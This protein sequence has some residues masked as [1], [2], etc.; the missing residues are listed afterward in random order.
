MGR[1][2]IA[3]EYSS[4]K[5]LQQFIPPVRTLCVFAPLRLCVKFL[6]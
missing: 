1:G 6:F 4:P 2:I 5:S 3:I